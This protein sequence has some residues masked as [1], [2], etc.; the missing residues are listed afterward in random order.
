MFRRKKTD[1]KRI[2]NRT[3][4]FQLIHSSSHQGGDGVLFLTGRGLGGRRAKKQPVKFR[5][6]QKAETAKLTATQ[7]RLLGRA[8]ALAHGK[9]K[10]KAKAK[11]RFHG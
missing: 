6:T 4:S 1:T 2:R 9:G 8:I 7:R 11:S 3:I 5:K 10:A